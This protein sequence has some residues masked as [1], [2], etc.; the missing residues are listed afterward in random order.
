MCKPTQLQIVAILLVTLMLVACKHTSDSRLL[1][2]DSNTFYGAS[3][4]KGIQFSQESVP[5]AVFSTELECSTREHFAAPL[6]YRVDKTISLA[7]SSMPFQYQAHGEQKYGLPLSP[8]DLV[9]VLIENGDGFNGRYVLDPNGYINLPLLDPISAAGK[10]AYLVSQEIELALIKNEIFQPATAVV[11]VQILNLAGVEVSVAG[12]VFQP[13]RVL[14]N[15]KTPNAL[16][17]EQIAA[18]G[19]FS[20]KRLLSEAIRSASGI[21]PDAKVDQIILIR[22]GWQVEVDLTGILTGTPVNDVPLIAGD[23]IIVPSTGCFQ[24]HLVRP[25]QITPKGFRVYMSNLIDSAGGNAAAAVGRYSTNLT[26]GSRLLQAAISANCVGGK[27]WTNAPRSI[28]LASTHP[29]TGEVQ[30]LE[31]S[32]EQIMK[33]PSR[34]DINPFLM[35]NDAVAC[36]DSSVTN[37]RDI[38]GTLYD[39][40]KP[41]AL[42]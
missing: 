7:T 5:N 16:L 2:P 17:D 6:N 31:R 11:S 24:Q 36:Y 32:V 41:I 3:K 18:F 4:T 25:S 37:V 12:A 10:P 38:A 22:N 26:Y 15:S 8:G 29:I 39:L 40:L 34:E 19:D 1:L 20:D 27:S 28:M 13:G 42:F 35:P 33:Y 23:Q 9:E 14:I 21:R 30:V